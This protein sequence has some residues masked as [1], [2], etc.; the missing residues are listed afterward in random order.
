V[1]DHDRGATRK[2]SGSRGGRLLRNA[3]DPTE[4]VILLER[5]RSENARRFADADETREAMQ[6]A[7]VFDEPHIFDRLAGSTHQA[8]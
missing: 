4:L 6:R 7:G 3:F 5:D 2:R 8:E 1:F